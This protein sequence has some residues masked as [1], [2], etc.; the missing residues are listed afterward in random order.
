MTVDFPFAK[1]E[2]RAAW[3]AFVL[4]PLARHAFSGPSPLFLIDANTRGSGKSL[5]ADVGGILATGTTLARMS[6][7]RDD[8][9]CRK[10]IT[11]L[12]L[13]GDSMS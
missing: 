7:P 4:T 9:E 12:A 1:P 8:E 3:L 2:H 5:L 11:A 13:A 6:N 10:R